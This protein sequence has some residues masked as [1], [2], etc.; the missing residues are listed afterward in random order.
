LENGT[1]HRASSQSS[2]VASLVRIKQLKKHG[3][4]Y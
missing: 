2:S 4:I 3:R 1:N